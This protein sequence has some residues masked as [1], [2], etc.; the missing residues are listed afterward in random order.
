MPPQ[1][2]NCRSTTVAVIDYEALGFDPP[3]VGKRAA[4][5]G[6]VPTDQSYGQWLNDQPRSV[7]TEVLGSKAPYFRRLARKHG[8]RDAIAKLVRDDGSELTLADLR[9]RYGRI[10]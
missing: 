1:H 6:M 8:P 3:P 4:Q 2:F 9:K 5:G 10:N 7:Q